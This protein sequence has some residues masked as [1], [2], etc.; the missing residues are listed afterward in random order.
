L[1]TGSGVF[2]AGHLV[3]I[4]FARSIR[5]EGDRSTV[6]GDRASADGNAVSAGIGGGIVAAPDARISDKSEV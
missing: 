2:L 5:D 6:G 1:A 4:A 3:D